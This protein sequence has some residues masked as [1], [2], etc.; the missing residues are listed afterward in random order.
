M[1]DKITPWYYSVTETRH[2]SSYVHTYRIQYKTGKQLVIYRYYSCIS[3]N[4]AYLIQTINFQKSD[5]YL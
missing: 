4:L 5:I 2:Y 3:R 1:N